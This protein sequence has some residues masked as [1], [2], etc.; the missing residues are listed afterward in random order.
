MAAKTYFEV[1]DHAITA[2]KDAFYMRERTRRPPLDNMNSLLSFLYT[3]LAHD[4]SAALEAVGLDPQVGFL[5]CERPGRPALALDV[6]EEFRP[7]LVD[8]LALSLVSE[9]E[10]AAQ[11]VKERE[12]LELQARV[13]WEDP[14]NEP[15]G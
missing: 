10:L 9:D 1:F 14:E 4:V 15:S 7:F 3:I 13:E 2:Q 5:H 12:D 11:L 8:R 6:M